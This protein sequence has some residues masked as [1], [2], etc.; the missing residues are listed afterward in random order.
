VNSDDDDEIIAFQK[1]EFKF[2]VTGN[3]YVIWIVKFVWLKLS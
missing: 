3:G 2:T 1:F